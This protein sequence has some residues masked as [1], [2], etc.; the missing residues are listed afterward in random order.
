MIKRFKPEVVVDAILAKKN[1]GTT[2]EMAQ[3]V[4]ALGPGFT[5]GND[6]DVVIET[7]RGHDLARVIY[8]GQ[9]EPNTGIPGDIAAFS[10]E[11]VNHA[12][13]AGVIRVIKDI[14]E[15]VEKGEI[16]AEI[17]HQ[18]VVA[19]VAGL[20]RGMIQNGT[21]VHKGMK[22]A[23]VDPRGTIVNCHTISDKARAIGGSVLEVILHRQIR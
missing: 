17:D 12:P 19:G 23:D 20:I 6:V 3:T 4:I 15:L 8:K 7:N 16:M 10:K 21:M 2:R 11:R 13:V 5:A 22:I 1:L 14:D 18:P 9:A